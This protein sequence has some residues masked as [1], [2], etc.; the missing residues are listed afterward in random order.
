MQK[1]IDE[2][3]PS[4]IHYAVCTAFTTIS[5]RSLG[6]KFIEILKA[7][8]DEMKRVVI[9]GKKLKTHYPTKV[10]KIKLCENINDIENS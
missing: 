8:V 3:Q 6:G 10:T 1:I 4:L 7:E 5:E 9:F 2:V